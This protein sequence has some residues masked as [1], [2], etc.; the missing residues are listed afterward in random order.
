[1]EIE[2]ARVRLHRA[3]RAHRPAD[4]QEAASVAEVDALLAGPDDPFTRE[5]AAGHITASAFVVDSARTATLLIWHT[6]LKRWLQPGGHCEPSDPSLCEA[7]MR[8][9]SEE[10]GL[11]AAKLLP[12]LSGDAPFDIDVHAIPARGDVPAH[13]HHDIRYLFEVVGQG[14]LTP[15]PESALRWVPLAE[16]AALDDASLS[17]MARKALG[18]GHAAT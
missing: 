8:E 18:Q 12:A 11:T 4:A 3:L 9:A 15:E 6:K 16:V 1:M 2:P 5:R 13:R 14:A 17:R 7:A 10:T